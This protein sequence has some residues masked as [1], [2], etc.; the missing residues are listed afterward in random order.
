MAQDLH[1]ATHELFSLV[2]QALRTTQDAIVG[3]GERRWRVDQNPHAGVAVEL[4]ELVDGK[5]TGARA[6]KFIAA[7]ERHRDYPEDLPFVAGQPTYLRQDGDD[8]LVAWVRDRESTERD[9]EWPPPAL[10]DEQRSGLESPFMQSLS[11]RIHPLAE[12]LRAGDP[13]ARGELMR[14][15]SDLQTEHAAEFAE[16]QS[17]MRSVFQGPESMAAFAQRIDGLVAECVHAGWHAGERWESD[18]PFPQRG[19]R[20]ER[21]NRVREVHAWIFGPAQYLSLRDAAV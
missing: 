4:H 5:P 21:G 8:V 19:V 14:V 2:H 6:T 18:V 1:K 12:R 16:L 3:E 15:M 11:E 17:T 13:E 7:R 20:L 9:G 10:T